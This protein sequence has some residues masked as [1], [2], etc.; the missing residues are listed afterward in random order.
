MSTFGARF[1]A[2]VYISYTI[3][4]YSIMPWQGRYKRGQAGRQDTAGQGRTGQK[5]AGRGAQT[6]ICMT[7]TMTFFERM[8]RAGQQVEQGGE[9][10]VEGIYKEWYAR[11][12]PNSVEFSSVQCSAV[13]S[14]GAAHEDDMRDSDERRR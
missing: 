3:H 2:H 1:A 4:T 6:A 13:Q 5:K 10:Q 12:E 9:G 7:F 11:A 8:R 14:S